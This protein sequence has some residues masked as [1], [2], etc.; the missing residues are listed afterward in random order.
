M[1][2]SF[3]LRKVSFSANRSSPPEK[4][5]IPIA[6]INAE[7]VAPEQ[8]SRAREI[9]QPAV[10]MATHVSM[11]VKDGMIQ[12]VESNGKT[13]IT[14]QKALLHED[15]AT[16]MLNWLKQ[17]ARQRH[18]QFLAASIP[19]DAQSTELMSKLWLQEDIVPSLLKPD[20]VHNHSLEELV[21]DVVSQFDENHLV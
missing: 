20:A 21:R 7:D 14:H 19:E 5:G 17:A 12:I 18:L 8:V 15:A 4:R 2:E 11:P 3:L 13:I 9:E 10:P 1:A 6:A 16:G